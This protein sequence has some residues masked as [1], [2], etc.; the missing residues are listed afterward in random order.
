MMIRILRSSFWFLLVLVLRLGGTVSYGETLI[1]FQEGTHVS[2]EE[3]LD[4]KRVLVYIEKSCAVCHHYVSELQR[5]DSELRNSI[6]LVS[7]STAA[8]TKEMAR[9]LPKEMRLFLVK[10]A[11]SFESTVATPTTRFGNKDKVGSLSCAELQRFVS[12]GQKGV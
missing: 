10:N 2:T 11:R 9:K 6:V 5:C 12:L 3:F 1:D 4:Q 8:Q 7:V